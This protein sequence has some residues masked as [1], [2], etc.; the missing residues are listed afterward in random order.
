M[1]NH[2]TAAAKSA[3]L[4]YSGAKF[5]S[6]LCPG[7]SAGWLVQTKPVFTPEQQ[8]RFCPLKF[9]RYPFLP[10]VGFLFLAC[11][12]QRRKKKKPHIAP[13]SWQFCFLLSIWLCGTCACA[14]ASLCSWGQDTPRSREE[15]KQLLI[16]LRVSLLQYPAVAD[17]SFFSP[18]I[19]SARRSNMN[20]GRGNRD[21]RTR[22]QDAG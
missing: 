4:Q 7:A 6:R 20:S 1:Q 2:P 19:C 3:S 18:M 15:H 5:C 16:A 22:N 11:Q 8:C 10:T 9:I 21:T 13:A 17:L 12:Q 14:S